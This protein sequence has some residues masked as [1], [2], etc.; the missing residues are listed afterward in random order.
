LNVKA[1]TEKINQILD[2][3]QKEIEEI[4]KVS[5]FSFR[6]TNDNF[7]TSYEDFKNSVLSTYPF[8]KSNY[9]EISNLNKTPV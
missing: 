1:N 3:S 2:N 8:L 5:F 9:E 7:E 4:E 6:I